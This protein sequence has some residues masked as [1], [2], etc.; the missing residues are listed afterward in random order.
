MILSV[1]RNVSHTSSPRESLLQLLFHVF[2][3]WSAQVLVQQK[4]FIYVVF[5]DSRPSASHSSGFGP[6]LAVSPPHLIHRLLAPSV[7]C[8]P[9]VTV[10]PCSP[11]RGKTILHWLRLFSVPCAQ[12][13]GAPKK[14]SAGVLASGWQMAPG[15]PPP[16]QN[17]PGY[18]TTTT[19]PWWM[20]DEPPRRIQPPLPLPARALGHARPHLRRSLKPQVSQTPNPLV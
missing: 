4:A 17:T 13:G 9:G 5:L 20:S 15:T 8:H 12:G 3:F 16:P 2:Y 1:S 10:P 6:R 19:T 18:P 7:E 14:A 11:C